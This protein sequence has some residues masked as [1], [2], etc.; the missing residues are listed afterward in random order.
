[1]FKNKL[2]VLLLIGISFLAG[3]FLFSFS[4]NIQTI[5]QRLTRTTTQFENNWEYCVITRI[6]VSNPPPDQM[7]TFT[8]NVTI[9]YFSYSYDSI[10]TKKSYVK[11]ECISNELNYAEFLQEKGLKNTPQAQQLASSKA[12][13][14]ALA[15]AMYVL[16]TRG[17]EVIG[18]NFVNFNFE[19]MDGNS[20]YKHSIY[21]RKFA[22][23][24]Q[25]SSQQ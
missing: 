9:N 11:S 3:I 23:Q 20:E 18:R 8:G 24:R 22:S 2:F 4:P 21:L 15:K 1:M 10:T 6:H 12:A 19:T 17:W 16:G 13:D 7:I 5:A 14:L 25:A